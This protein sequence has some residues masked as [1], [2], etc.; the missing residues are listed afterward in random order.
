MT[1]NI[2]GS[3][4]VFLVSN[5]VVY[6]KEYGK[7]PYVYL[8][9]N[10]KSYVGVHPNMKPMGI[11]ADDE[12]REL[13]K[14]CHALFDKTWKDNKERSVRYAELAEKLDIKECH[15]SWMS[16]EELKKALTIIEAGTEERE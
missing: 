4:N 12:M 16:K 14:K 10:C 3:E 8:C 1:C 7:V 13:R 6:G 11:L 2:C 5:S 9:E 15:F